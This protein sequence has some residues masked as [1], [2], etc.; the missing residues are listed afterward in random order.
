[1]LGRKAVKNTENR[2][3]GRS[4]FATI[5]S[6][7]SVSSTVNPKA[8]NGHSRSTMGCGYSHA[9][10]APHFHCGCCHSIPTFFS[11]KSDLCR[12]ISRLIKQ[13]YLAVSSLPQPAFVSSVTPSPEPISASISTVRSFIQRPR[14]RKALVVAGGIL[15][16]LAI[17]GLVTGVIVAMFRFASQLVLDS[18]FTLLMGVFISS[19]LYEVRSSFNRMTKR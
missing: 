6:V 13:T 4:N 7:L 5:L 2:I 19:S 3:Q 12:Y 8:S 16:V 9:R 17:W 15:T 14:V 10:Y 11:S 18:F 1:M